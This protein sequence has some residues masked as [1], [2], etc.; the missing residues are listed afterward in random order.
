M[1]NGE[2]RMVNEK[3]LTLVLVFDP[4]EEE[5]HEWIVS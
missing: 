3:R 2:L 4:K 5:M 1:V